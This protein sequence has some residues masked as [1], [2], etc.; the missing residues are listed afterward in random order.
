VFLERNDFKVP[1]N[2]K[3]NPASMVR[4]GGIVS[5]KRSKQIVYTN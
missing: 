5:V 1:E 4:P 3:E 2:L